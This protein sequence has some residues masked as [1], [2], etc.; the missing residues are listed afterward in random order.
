M[1]RTYNGSG[2]EPEAPV[3][4]VGTPC[5]RPCLLHA[6]RFG[7]TPP[8]EAQAGV[9]LSH[10]QEPLGSIT[11]EDLELEGFKYLPAFRFYWKQRYRAKGW[12]PWDTISVLEVRP[13]TFDD[14]P[15]MGSVLF[16]HL[17]GEWMVGE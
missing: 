10:R 1:F 3:I 14:I 5:P 7:R 11:P 4:P 13:M 2:R 12:R 8:W 16:D 15:L 9:L 17:Y 6:Q